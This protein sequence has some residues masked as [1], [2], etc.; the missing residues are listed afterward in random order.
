MSLKKKASRI[1]EFGD[2]QT[3]VSLVKQV[4]NLLYRLGVRPFSVIEPNCGVGNFIFGAYDRFP[5]ANVFYGLDINKQYI[6]ILLKKI[7]S[8]D[9]EKRI[10]LKNGSFFD[11]N[12]SN[13]IRDLPEPILFLGNP[14]WVT[15]SELGAI[16]GSNLPKKT[17][18]QN[19]NGFDAITGKSNFDISEWMLIKMLDSINRRNAAMAFLCKTAVAR[20][21]FK[22]AKKNK[23]TI[24][25]SLIYK[26]NA[27]KHFNASVDAC[28][29]VCLTSKQG[30]NYDCDVYDGIN[31]EKPST[32]IGFKDNTLIANV[33]SYN[34]LKELNC[35]GSPYIW[36][37]GIK[38]DA[39]RVM[40]LIKEGDFYRNG[41]GELVKIERELLYPLLKSSDVGNGRVNEPRR[42][43]IVTQ[44]NIGQDTGHIKNIAPLTW[45][46]LQEHKQTLSSR[47]SP[48]YRK[49]PLF[50]IFG[51]G[52][53]SF[54]AWKVAISGLYKKL[55][56]QKI[57]QYDGKPFVLDDTCYFI[58]C[59]SEKEAITVLRLLDSGIAREFFESIIFW[60]NKRPITKEILQRLNI[61]SLA[62]ICGDK[63]ILFL[64]SK[65]GFKTQQTLF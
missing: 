48:V 4:T 56:F 46:Y 7:K 59:Y 5:D 33:L 27:K 49:K 34:R 26:I 21:V 51:V 18:F 29:F 15:S 41:F 16:R 13:V 58:P 12:W 47:T 43:L 6:D 17:N 63:D 9:L 8:L 60:D 24:S 57:G 65:K 11:V 64:L 3:P 61:S 55:A 2:F 45:S 52:P 44:K 1:I 31:D 35:G 30:A 42:W 39:S 50:S 40:E 62:K 19:M 28:L 36:R 22:Y 10:I 20:K 14:P 37:S 25:E 54:S 32:V 53:Y 23:I 38:H